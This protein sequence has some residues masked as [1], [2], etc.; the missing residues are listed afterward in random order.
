[1]AHLSDA[2]STPIQPT[3]RLLPITGK[4]AGTN[5]GRG[6]QSL[7]WYPQ[8]FKKAYNHRLN[9]TLEHQFPGQI[10]TSVTYFTNFGNQH[11]TQPLNNIDPALQEKYQ[12][13][14][15]TTSVANPFYHYQTP[16]LIPGPLY[17]QPTVTLGSLLVKYPL[18]GGLYELGKL[19]AS[20]RYNELELRVQKRFSKGYNFLFGYMYIREKTQQY[21]ND[22]ATYKDQLT[23]QDSDQPH[24]RITAA[25]SYELPFGKGK[26]YFSELPR[27]AD[28][29]IGGWQITGQLTFNTGDYPRFGN[30][31]VTGN[32]C[33]NVPSGY[34]FNPS[35][36]SPL[37]ANTYVMRTNP[38]QY[39]CITGPKFFNLDASLSKNVHITER[40]QGQLK[41]TAYNAPNKLN[42]GARI[43]T[44]M[45][46][47]LDKRCIRALRLAQFGSQ[48]ATYGNQAGRQVE[49]GFRIL[50]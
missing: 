39:S 15:N 29:L 9:L 38:L 3:I 46:R 5:L 30:Y 50:F 4:G 47:H 25:G 7:I 11:Y 24:H 28:A 8:D 41:M 19:G 26:T 18:Y 2:C 21:F 27:A 37:P 17:N 40:I 48:T 45:M 16:T 49:I 34:Y 33:Q 10:V 1:M 20:E 31:I 44:G 42:L 13:T 23:Y 32:P 14:L 6:G 22:L 12:N 43:R 35:A 36:F